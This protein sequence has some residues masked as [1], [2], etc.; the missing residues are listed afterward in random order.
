MEP[1]SAL[2]SVAGL[3]GSLDAI[4]R[5]LEHL[6]YNFLPRKSEDNYAHADSLLQNLSQKVAQVR[7][8]LDADLKHG[9]V[10]ELLVPL[11]FIERGLDSLQETIRSVNTYRRFRLVGRFLRRRDTE[12]AMTSILLAKNVIRIIMTLQEI[13][14]SEDMFIDSFW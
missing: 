5:T 1:L 7:S 8:S 13:D 12:A 3:L 11:Q 9:Q 6:T 2:A 10:E 4:L 14:R